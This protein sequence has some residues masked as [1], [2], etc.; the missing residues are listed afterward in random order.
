MMSGLALQDVGVGQDL[1]APLAHRRKGKESRGLL[2]LGLLVFPSPCLSSGA[3]A[4]GIRFVIS[5]EVITI[6]NH[7]NRKR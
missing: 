6:H 4:W 2:P 5:K 1:N 7:D 3:P